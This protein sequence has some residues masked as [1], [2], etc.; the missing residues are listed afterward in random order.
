MAHQWHPIEDLGD[1]FAESVH[2]ELH[3]LAEVWQ[4][5]KGSFDPVQLQIFNDK[6]KREWAIETGLIERIYTVNSGVTESL[7]ELG[8]R[9][10]LIPH[11]NGNS[12]GKIAAMM[13]DH[14]NV[15][16]GLF[17]FVKNEREL[18]VSYVKELHAA[19]T[20]NQETTE[21]IDQFGKVTQMLLLHGAFKIAPNNPRTSEG[22]L[23]EY[24]PP[25]QVASEMDK[26]IAMHL[27][28]NESQISPLV[29]AAWLHHR[30]TQIHPFQDGNGRVARCLATLIFIK[31]EWLPLVILNKTRNRYLN[32]LKS[33][34]EGDLLPLIELFADEQKDRLLNILEIAKG[35]SPA[36]PATPE[37]MLISIAAEK[38]KQIGQ[39]QEI[40]YEN[41]KTIALILH[42]IADK[43]LQI[44]CERIQSTDQFSAYVK[45][46]KFGEPEDYYFRK[47][48][49]AVAKHLGYYANSSDYC[50]W[51]RLAISSANSEM[52]PR[53]EILILFHSIG[54]E[55]RGVIVCSSCFIL[56]EK[57]DG[58][59]QISEPEILSDKI[60]QIN[61][62]EDAKNAQKRFEKWLDRVIS[63]GLYYWQQNL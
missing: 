13:S 12:P 4:E 47:Q 25:E 15:I 56:R 61:Y 16:D 63:A 27:E 23:H 34:D 2:Q 48:V 5:Q 14:E 8:I 60:F 59:V 24:C 9:A 42:D 58:G 7:I 52:K 50:A 18:S 6:L 22:E 31:A 40:E 36:T 21:A 30:F 43:R 32:S 37:D 11:E 19:L 41:A 57:M 38:Q 44:T 49:V 20:R 29:S 51:G 17:D 28:H 46:V 45:F 26:L 39:E 54:H 1:S 53:A 62:K 33:A 55:Y 3:H 35:I 10:D